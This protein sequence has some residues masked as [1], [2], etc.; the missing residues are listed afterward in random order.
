VGDQTLVRELL[1]LPTDRTCIV[2]LSLGYPAG[3]PLA[4]IERPSR[5]AFDDVVHPDRW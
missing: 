2:L 1:D 5:R 3:K 4:P